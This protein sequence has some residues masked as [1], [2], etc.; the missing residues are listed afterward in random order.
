MLAKRGCSLRWAVVFS[1]ALVAAPRAQQWVVVP[2]QYDGQEGTSGGTVAGFSA[3]FREQILVSGTA[4]QALQ[5]EEI[6][7][8]WFR[9]D[10]LFGKTLLSSWSNIKVTVAPALLPPTAPSRVFVE[11]LGAPSQVVF[12]GLL[13]LD[14]SSAPPS[15][16]PWATPFVAMV[17]F[18]TTYSYTGGDLCIE[19]EGTP[20]YP[21]L[22]FVWW[23]DVAHLAAVGSVQHVGSPCGAPAA[24]NALTADAWGRNMVPGATF[25]MVSFGRPGTPGVMLLGAPLPTPLSLAFMGASGCELYLLPTLQILGQH[26]APVG[27]GAVAAPLF[28]DVHLPVHPG[29]L[30]AQ[31]RVQ[32]ANLETGSGS[33]NPARITTTN[34]LDITLGGSLPS[35][36]ISV[37]KSEAVPD[38]APL[39]DF[40]M[41]S[42]SRGPVLRFGSRPAAAGGSSR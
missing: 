38:G 20:D 31:F 7:S 25:T 23:V 15:P 36:P 39:P 10:D 34:A 17:P 13:P 35:G 3:R 11:N 33:S 27:G 30:G 19:I 18:D 1:L 41:V 8:L 32:F 26:S 4:L 6:D 21:P 14:G 9:R 42:V 24:E 29:F 16:A 37:V 5:G 22:D 2:S 40:G 28:W 12:D